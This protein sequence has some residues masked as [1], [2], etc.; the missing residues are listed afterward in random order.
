MDDKSPT[1]LKASY[2]Q[3][4]FS[5]LGFHDC[6]ITGVK[7]NP[8]AFSITLTLE[9]I[10]EWVAPTETAGCFRFWICPAELE[11]EN[12][13]DVSL[14]LGWESAV[15]ECRI[16][17]LYRRGERRTPN[18]GVQTQWDFE[19]STPSG[20]ITIWAAAWILRI[21]GPPVL[22]KTQSLSGG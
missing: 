7:W 19:L 2:N 1:P 6:P 20:R 14:D 8:R 16:Q 18:G 17:D 21:V 15:M 22:T 13:G 9:Y 5:N 11:F 12:V 3:D 10:V 4:D